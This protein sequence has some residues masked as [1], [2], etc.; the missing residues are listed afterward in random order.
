MIVLVNGLE[1]VN[2]VSFD[3]P[4]DSGRLIKNFWTKLRLVPLFV[5]ISAYFFS[6]DSPT[7]RR[8][9]VHDYIIEDPRFLSLIFNF[10]GSSIVWELPHAWQ[11]QPTPTTTK[12][13]NRK[14]VRRLTFVLLHRLWQY[15]RRYD[16]YPSIPLTCFT[17]LK[18][19]QTEIKYQL[20]FLTSKAEQ[21]QHTNR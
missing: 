16:Q 19:D 20:N 18:L 10:C 14:P 3:R 21:N 9:C 11:L 6:W 7:Y 8:S 17:L 15:R 1:L 4:R 2:Q 12:S 5:D 13:L